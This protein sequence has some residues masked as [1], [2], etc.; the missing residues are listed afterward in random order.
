MLTL[1]E[2]YFD[3]RCSLI[4]PYLQPWTVLFFY[5]LRRLIMHFFLQAWYTCK[6]FICLLIQNCS[7]VFNWTAS[8]LIENVLFRLNVRNYYLKYW[9]FLLFSMAHLWG[10]K[11]DLDCLINKG[12]WSTSLGMEFPWREEPIKSCKCDSMISSSPSCCPNKKLLQ[13]RGARQQPQDLDLSSNF[14]N[15]RFFIIIRKKNPKNNKRRKT[16]WEK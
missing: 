14:M 11:W 16:Y 7:Y 8:I 13:G 4:K 5:K 6:N 15:A 10:L 2:A 1:A 9:L 3:M 12:L